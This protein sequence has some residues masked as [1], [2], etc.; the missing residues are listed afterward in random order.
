[1]NL[2]YSSVG[3]TKEVLANL[4]LLV[5]MMSKNASLETNNRKN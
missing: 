2:G 3:H 1:M 5:P 4:V